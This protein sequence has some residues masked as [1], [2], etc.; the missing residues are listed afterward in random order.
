MVKRTLKEFGIGTWRELHPSKRDYTHYS[1][2]NNSYARIDYFFMNKNNVYRVKKC[3]IQEAD[4]SDHC[5]VHL[6]V[7]LEG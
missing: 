2:P 7:N 4:V 1:P 3:E 6:E 5:A